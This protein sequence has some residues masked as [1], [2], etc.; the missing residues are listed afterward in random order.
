V[1][2]RSSAITSQVVSDGELAGRALGYV[3]NP[4]AL[5]YEVMTTSSTGVGTDV[6]VKNTSIPITAASL[7]L[8]TGAAQD[9]TLTG[10][11]A[12]AIVRGGAKGTTAAADVTSNPVDANTQALH[13][14]G[15]KVTQ[16]VSLAAAVDVSDRV[17]RLL[18]IIASITAAVDVSDR[19]ARLVGRIYGSQGNQLLQTAVNFN[20]Q[21]EIA[22]GAA[23]IDP[24]AI[25]ALTNADVVKAQLQDNAGTAITL[26]QKVAASS[27]PAVIASDQ[28][29][30][31]QARATFGRP[32][33]LITYR[34]LYRLAARPYALS[35]AF[36][37]AGRKQ[38]AT[39]HHPNTST[40]TVKL[41]HV[42][43][44]L[45][46]SSAAAIL[47][48][49]LVRV[50]A[51]PATGN[52][53]ITPTPL[54]PG[55]AAADSVALALP[56]TA[57]TEAAIHSFTEWNLGITAG[58]SVVNPPPPLSWIDLIGLAPGFD[59]DD[60]GTLPTIRSG[61]LEGYA[62]TLDASVLDTVKGFVLI[63]F[64]EE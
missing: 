48:A 34:A 49:D 3:W 7:P 13:V 43:L 37:A 6:N 23:L 56:T 2:T 21:V 28:W 36:G 22:V 20:S 62:V 45:E 19:A 4:S 12:K 9:A 47:V 46:S 26:G 29:N 15:S 55:D 41:R 57:G 14:D 42:W 1:A 52:P 18:G 38:Y 51:A 64:T 25:R 60:E 63:E 50:T 54:N 44:A 39:I 59:P 8:P 16:P 10:G 61:V 31:A 17:G 24:R 53:A 40:K 27:V 11:T 35:N 5:A 33:K 32:R 58:G 30:D